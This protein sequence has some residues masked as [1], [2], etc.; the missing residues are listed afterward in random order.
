V[1]A[2]QVKHSIKEGSMGKILLLFALILA[3]CPM[4]AYPCDYQGKSNGI[5]TVVNMEG[6]LMQCTA[7]GWW[8]IGFAPS[9]PNAPATVSMSQLRAAL[10]QARAYQA[11]QKDAAA[12]HT[13]DV[14][15]DPKQGG[16]VEMTLDQLKGTIKKYLAAHASKM[17]NMPS[18]KDFSNKAK[19]ETGNTSAPATVDGSKSS[20]P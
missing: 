14:K 20:T 16:M 18:T 17:E 4:A 9:T 5:G 12:I 19:V 11:Q 8:F 10:R 6:R 3:C 2:V 13:T 1:T 15:L 7:V